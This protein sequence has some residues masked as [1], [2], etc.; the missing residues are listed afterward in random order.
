[1]TKIVIANEVYLYSLAVPIY[2]IIK[3]GGNIV[4]IRQKR[5]VSFLTYKKLNIKLLEAVIIASS[6]ILIG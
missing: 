5:K 3:A 6:T 4:P 1:M 2:L